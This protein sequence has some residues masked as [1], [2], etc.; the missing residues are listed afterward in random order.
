[1]PEA[2]DPKLS[3]SEIVRILEERCAAGV[4][5]LDLASHELTVSAGLGRMVGCGSGMQTR[6]LSEV[7]HLIHPAD[8][9]S[10]Q[11]AAR[12]VER[13]IPM[14]QEL[15][16][17]TPQ[18]RLRR[19]GLE[20]EFLLDEN[21]R[22]T[23]VVGVAVDATWQRRDGAAAEA[24]REQLHNVVTGV[25]PMVWAA[26]PDGWLTE[27]IGWE[28][29]T[30]MRDGKAL[31]FDWIEGV[32]PDDREPTL[33]QWYVSIERKTLC[34]SEMRF[35]QRDGGFRWC[36][37]YTAPRFAKSGRIREWSGMAIDIHGQVEAREADRMRVITGAQLRASRGLLKWSVGRLSGVSGLTPAVIRRLENNEGP[38][39]T[40]KTAADALAALL[41]EAGIEFTFERDAL[42]GVRPR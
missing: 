11:D 7:L 35:L 5:S 27:M 20:C 14:H 26:R 25:A 37:V 42:P 9:I 16:V 13:A 39:L 8:R 32:H 34:D 15:R 28:T 18:G 40:S 1:M 10:V 12:A 22:A 3:T 4:F 38:L 17:I 2:L 33:A 19:L 24:G 30:G 21:G 23:K 41:V 29:M 31:G 6:P 36:R